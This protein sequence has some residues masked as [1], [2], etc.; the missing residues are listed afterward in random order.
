MLQRL[1]DWLLLGIVAKLTDLFSPLDSN[2]IMVDKT[3]DSSFDPFVCQE[4]IDSGFNFFF[5]VAVGEESD[6]KGINLTKLL[7]H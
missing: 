1:R 4:K 6:C 2:Q 5:H 7:T 3:T